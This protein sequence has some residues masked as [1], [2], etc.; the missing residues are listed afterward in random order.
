M[1]NAPENPLSVEREI[2]DIIGCDREQVDPYTERCKF[3]KRTRERT[4]RPDT[5]RSA[6]LLRKE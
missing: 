2:C 1:A 6:V 5:S 4:R 3:C